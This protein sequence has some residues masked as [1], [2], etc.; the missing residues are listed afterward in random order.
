M[1]VAALR[2][3]LVET[4]LGIPICGL[5]PLSAGE[6]GAARQPLSTLVAE[7]P[8]CPFELARRG[9]VICTD[10][11]LGYA[12]DF[13]RAALADAHSPGSVN[14]RHT[15]GKHLPFADGVVDPCAVSACLST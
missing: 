2:T 6:L 13:E 9:Y 7:S 10:I 12:P 8:F 5:E 15:N 1:E 3:A 14:F 11:D 4:Y